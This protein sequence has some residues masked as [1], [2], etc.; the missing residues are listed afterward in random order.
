MEAVVRVYLRN[1]CVQAEEVV[2]ELQRIVVE[3]QQPKGE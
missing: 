2:L 3:K 1:P